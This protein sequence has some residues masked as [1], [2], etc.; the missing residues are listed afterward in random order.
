MQ[1]IKVNLLALTGFGNVALR[2]LLTQS[3]QISEVLTREEEKEFPYYEEEHLYNLAMKNN[4]PVKF[5]PSSGDWS[6]DEEAD[7]NLVCTF[8]RIL[9]EKHMSK[10]KLN[11][12]IHPSL[13]PSYKG[14][15]PTNW[16][17][18]NKEKNCGITAHILTNKVDEGDIIFQKK[19]PLKFKT[20]NQLRKF[21]STKT[22]EAVQYIISHFPDYKIMHSEYKESYYS[23]YYK[24]HGGSKVN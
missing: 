22:A 3:T 17:I 20:D 7:I 4:V 23:S 14:P 8:H 16:M 5:I 11:I 24:I 2:T 21:L 12:N 1:N 19:F 13:L 9:H 15:T 10:A 6:I 18:H